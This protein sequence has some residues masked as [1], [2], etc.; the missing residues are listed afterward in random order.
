MNWLALRLLRPYLTV[1]A[2]LSVASTALVLIGARVIGRQLDVH[3]ITVEEYA[4]DR[5]GLCET[6]VNC[7]PAGAAN[8]LAQV[9]A[10]VA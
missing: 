4:P 7:L 9:I 3:G 5:T 6:A 8:D 10:L 2:G 1:A